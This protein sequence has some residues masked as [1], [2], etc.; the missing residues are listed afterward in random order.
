MSG[1]AR[2]ARSEKRH[3]P[4]A[5]YIAI[6]LFA[7]TAGYADPAAAFSFDDITYWIGAGNN[8]AAF[9]VDWVDDVSQPAAL[10]WGYRWDGAATGA[11]MLRAIVADDPRLFA[12]LGGTLANPTAVYGLGYDADDDGEFGIDDG[13]VFDSQGFAFTAPADLAAP[14]DAGDYYAEG[15]FTGFW[16]YGVAESN[17]YTVGSWS[18]TGAGM[19]SRSLADGSWDSWTFTPNFDFTAFAENPVA[20][21]PPFPPGDFDH[22]GHVT[23]SDYAAWRQA[24]GS[25][26][27]PAA[28]G[29]HNGVVDAAD[30]VVWRKALN[31]VRGQAM[32]GAT[33]LTTP[34]P[35]GAAAIFSFLFI[36][37]CK[38]RERSQIAKG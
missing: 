35:N 13:T 28:D 34:E 3:S 25:T 21:P 18:D 26:S 4:V 2:G 12:K 38:R 22:D 29:N 33:N 1:E 30:Y 10:T 31:A 32:A 23:A 7:L 17:P 9:V 36:A 15:W 27:E 5:A 16:H 37:V 8:R 11:Q 20:A 19:A 24:F 14:T 6:A